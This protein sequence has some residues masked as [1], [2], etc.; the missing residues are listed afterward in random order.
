MP[1]TAKKI[2]SLDEATIQAIPVPTFTLDGAGRITAW[3]KAVAKLSGR[4]REE[5]LGKK[6]WGVFFSSRKENP[7][8]EAIM[9]VETV[10][11]DFNT[12]AWDEPGDY[13]FHVVPHMGEDDEADGAVVNITPAAS[14]KN[15]E[16]HR[17]EMMV[18]NAPNALMF[19]DIHDDFKI[20]Y[21]NQATIERLRPLEQYLPVAVDDILGQSIDVFHKMPS[22]Q[23]KMLATDSHLPHR[24]RVKLGPET[25]D[26]RVYPL[27]NDKGEY[28]GPAVTWD[29]ITEAVALEERDAAAKKAVAQV[30]V[31]LA[32]VAKGDIESL[33]EETFDG[34]LES[35]KGNVN[36]ITVMLQRFRAEFEALTEDARQGNLSSRT[37]AGQF[38][39]AYA[40]IMEGA[41]ELLDTI[42][43]PIEEIK[44][45][46]GKV[47]DGDLA[48]YVTGNY[49]G[50]H[51]DLKVALNSTLDSLNKVL[52]EVLQSGEQ[53][54]TGSEQ[55]RDSA[56]DLSQGAAEQ[57]STVEE[58]SAQMTEMAAQTKANA[59]NAAQASRLAL[60]AQEAGSDGDSKMGAMVGAMKEIDEASQNI[61]KII[62]VI[63][64]IAFQTNLL[65]LN[66][67][68]E[69]A[70][71]GVHGKGFA[72]V[73]EEVR[74][75]AARSANAAKETTEMIEGSIKKVEFGASIAED[76][77]KAL[78]EIVTGVAEVTQLVQQIAAASNEQAEGISQI[79]EGLSQVNLVIQNNTATSEE[80]A[81]SAEELSQ[82]AARL[83]EALGQ[84]TLAKSRPAQ[85]GLPDGVSPDL[86]AAVQ[87]YLSAAGGAPAA[88]APRPAARPVSAPKPAAPTSASQRISFDDMDFGKY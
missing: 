17:L 37:D 83:Q 3:N 62:K 56:K 38:E 15:V 85:G 59:E 77:A 21:V 1:S 9:G 27:Y 82:Q 73:A 87:A 84:F 36:Q 31:A 68:V 43:E 41:N 7:F 65:A 75:L 11:E 57:A 52:G 44:A 13:H 4:G 6:A 24:T 69:A 40:T 63:D 70:R 14:G 12:T 47:S 42:L 61:S 58:I 32:K 29:F 55:I 35:M 79:N 67:A 33:I 80:S 72:V 34:D 18:E 78:S 30:Q 5:V 23:R 74:N 2:F 45:Q 39:G 20:T 86:L 8:D 81:A 53:V 50:D 22:H 66:A 76:T 26:L 60:T 46:L 51:A 49:V 88:P 10:K 28:T 16:G 25:M 19:C 71:A 54:S 64:E 48:A